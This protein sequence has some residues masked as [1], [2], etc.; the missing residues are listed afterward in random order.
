MTRVSPITDYEFGELMAPFS[1]SH[2]FAVAVSGGA[3]SLALT[4][5]AHRYALSHGIAMTALTVDHHL[6]D[7]STAEANA[8]HALLAEQGIIHTVLTWQHDTPPTTKIQEKARCHRYRLLWDWCQMNNVQTLLTAHHQGDQVETFFMR[9]AHRSGLKGLSSMR[10]CTQT[11]FGVLLRPFLST[12]KER[13]VATL[14]IFGVQW[15]DDPSNKNHKFERIR[16]RYAL[17]ILEDTGVLTAD[18]ISI[19]IQKLQYIDDFLD[20]SVHTF[21]K[22][23]EATCF[24]LIA[25]QGQHFVLRR[26]ILVYLLKELSSQSYGAPDALIDRVAAQMMQPTF[27]GTT[28]GG[29]YLKRSAGG[30]VRVQRENRRIV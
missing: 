7:H 6:R 21:F 11:P 28:L 3:D 16:L 10:S 30:M 19:S 8:V 18:A 15:Y 29:L 1:I 27:K 20:E 9:L 13:L 14:K 4:L 24:P 5:L 12:P 25:F 26:R 17:N 22:T 2:S 23:Y